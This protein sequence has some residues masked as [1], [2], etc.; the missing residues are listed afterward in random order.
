MFTHTIKSSGQRCFPACW[1][2]TKDKGAGAREQAYP[3]MV[4][5]SGQCNRVRADNL[6][7]I[8]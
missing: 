6:Q 7:V 8:T 1:W 5:E 4:F 3:L 2:P